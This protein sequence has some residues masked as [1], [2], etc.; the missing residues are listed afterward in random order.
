M[1]QDV[2]PGTPY[3]SLTSYQILVQRVHR[4]I[5]SPA[6]QAGRSVT[7]QL[8]P[9]EL[10]EDWESLLEQLETDESVRVTRAGERTANIS[11]TNRH[12][13]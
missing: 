5:N 7:L 13:A 12:P 4:Q 6:A 10:L 9:G 3:H 2:P 8:Q 1:L 11:W